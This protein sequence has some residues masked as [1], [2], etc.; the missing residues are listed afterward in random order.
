MEEIEKETEGLGA[1]N[2]NA[3]KEYEKIKNRYEFLE[4]QSED[5]KKAKKNLQEIMTETEEKIILK[6]MESIEQ[7]N[8]NFQEIFTKIF[9]GG[10][11]ELKLTDKNEILNAGI[12]ILI[13]MPN[14]KRQALSMLSGGERV[15]TVTALLFAIIKYQK[16]SIC[17]LDEIDASLDEINLIK[18]GKF[19][20]EYSMKTQFIL[21]THRKTLM[22]YLD[23]IYGVTM[24]ETEI[25][26]ILSVKLT[27]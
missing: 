1:I 6:F 15:L 9:E 21:I 13:K 22:K 14:K 25:S 10:E 23:K 19:L 2:P 18:F 7:I 12:E 17:I 11:S 8:K 3:I 20:R 24:D 26:Q 27:V 5:L 16:T 4:R